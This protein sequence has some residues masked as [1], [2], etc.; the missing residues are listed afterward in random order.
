MSKTYLVIGGTGVIGQFVTRQLVERGHRPVVLTQSGNTEFIRDV[1]DRAEIVKVDVRDASALDKVVRDH[2]ITHIAH[3]SAIL[4]TAEEDPRLA[5]QVNVEGT[6]NVLEAARANGVRRV[7]YTSSKG[8]YGPIT[9]EHGH[10]TYRP[11]SEDHPCRPVDVYGL[12]KLAGEHLGV[13]YQRRHGLDFIALRFASVLGPGKTRRHGA[14]GMNAAII[15]NAMA[16]RPTHIPVG[17]DARQDTIYNADTARGIICAL[18]APKPRHHVFNI[19]TGRAIGLRD[20]AD[21]VHT[22]YPGAEIEPRRV[23]RRL[24]SL[25]HATMAGSSIWA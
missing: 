13:V 11:L 10:P 24:F 4:G 19:G 8:A 25:S 20:I 17:G 1:E 9:G 15:E 12:T 6:I 2:R 3:L 23:C 16:G 22:F 14:R 18:D 5:V 7:V 21:A